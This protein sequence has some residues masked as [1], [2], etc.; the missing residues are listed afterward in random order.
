MDVPKNKAELLSSMNAGRKEWDD[1]LAQLSDQ[2]LRVKGIEGDWSIK[3]VLAHIC[4]YQ[5][6]MA[7]TLADGKGDGHETAALDSWYQTNLSMFRKEHP[8]LPEQIQDVKGDQVNLVFVA[9]YRFKL[10]SE[11][12][13][14]EAQSYQRLL[15]WVEIYPDAELS[16]PYGDTGRSL[17][18][19]I[20]NQCYLHYH[21]HLRTIQAWM[22]QKGMVK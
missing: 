5:Q 13:E 12:R 20:P 9:A 15:H 6:Y 19:I 22:K 21:T 10:P 11:V 17:L 1:T 7:A 16:G 4:A 3:D 14:M 8:E 2:D 18:H